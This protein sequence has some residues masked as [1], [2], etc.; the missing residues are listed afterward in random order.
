MIVKNLADCTL[1]VL[2]SSASSSK[3]PQITN[4][5]HTFQTFVPTGMDDKPYRCPQCG[6]Y[7]KHKSSLKTH[8]Q[9]ECNK[10]PQFN[11]PH[12]SYRAKKK[13]N[14]KSHIVMKHSEVI[15][16]TF[17]GLNLW[18]KK[19]NVLELVVCMFS[20]PFSFSLVW[21][22]LLSSPLMGN[23]SFNE[24]VLWTCPFTFKGGIFR[25]AWTTLIWF[26]V[27]KYFYT[28]WRKIYN[29]QTINCKE[30]SYLPFLRYVFFFDVK[31]VSP[32]FKFHFHSWGNVR[33]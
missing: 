25:P 18:I 2:N 30:F 21:A 22:F 5:T 16:S 20:N 17:S 19:T 13:N 15:G 1:L 26:E 33:F 27:K 9:F 10:D 14:L 11:C 8:L 4:I 3:I 23:N 32:F 6:N 12:C 7:Y 29:P 31:S 28:C 24:M